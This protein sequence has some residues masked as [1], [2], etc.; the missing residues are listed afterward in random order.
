L[1]FVTDAQGK[2]PWDGVMDDNCEVRHMA[3][4]LLTG[5][6]ISI[7]F[8]MQPLT[9]T[10]PVAAQVTRHGDCGEWIAAIIAEREAQNRLALDVRNRKFKKIDASYQQNVTDEL[11]AQFQKWEAEAQIILDKITANDIAHTYEKL[12]KIAGLNEELARARERNLKAQ[13]EIL[14][15]WRTK[16]FKQIQAAQDAFE[17]AVKR[18]NTKAQREIER[19]RRIECVKR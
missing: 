15:K 6:L 9:F 3:M 14:L 2:K 17:K 16:R 11:D 1:D 5:L 4:R 18:N 8:V 7:I 10:N 13:Q 12:T 19:I